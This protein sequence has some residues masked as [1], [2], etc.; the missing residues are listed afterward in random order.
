MFWI[1]PVWS[2]LTV[3]ADGPHGSEKDV[4]D[5]AEERVEEMDHV[6]DGFD[7]ENEDGQDGDDD[8]PVGDAKKITFSCC[9]HFLLTSKRKR[10][11]E[12]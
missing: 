4:D 11:V 2:R 1:R 12:P 3:D 9:R 10:P 5:E 6:Q 7:Q 8:I